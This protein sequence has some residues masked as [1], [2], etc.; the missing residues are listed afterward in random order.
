M[1]LEDLKKSMSTLEKVLA[2]TNADIK[3]DVSASETAKAKLLKKLRTNIISNIIL[4]VIFIASIFAGINQQE[5]P[6]NL[7]IYLITLILLSAIWNLFIYTKINRV[8]IAV[9]PP[10]KL[11]IETSN[12]KMLMMSG[13]ILLLMGLV[14]FFTLVFPYAWTYNHFGFFGMIGGI[15]AVVI[16]SVLYFY[17][18]YIKLF[19]DLN[20]IK[21]VD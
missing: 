19:R 1:E 4:A 7:R 15:I 18:K 14:V 21:E 11:F 5:F 9:L 17:P 6:I 2:K 16:Y 20:S 12:I 13:E 8:N 10:A 3:I